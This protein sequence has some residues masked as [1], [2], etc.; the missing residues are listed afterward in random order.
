VLV[1][2]VVWKHLVMRAA[3]NSPTRINFNSATLA[4]Q[5][6]HSAGR[7]FCAVAETLNNCWMKTEALCVHRVPFGH[8]TRRHLAPWSQTGLV[9]AQHHHLDGRLVCRHLVIG[10]GFHGGRNRVM[11]STVRAPYRATA[12][13]N[14]S[15]KEPSARCTTGLE[16]HQKRRP[17]ATQPVRQAGS[18]ELYESMAVC[19]VTARRNSHFLI[20]S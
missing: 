18:C 5:L 11:L 6:R 2:P 10:C 7:Q 17:A 16:W 12:D 1:V 8:M 13:C 20:A 4:A 3:M 14:Q 19:A 9:R 15:I